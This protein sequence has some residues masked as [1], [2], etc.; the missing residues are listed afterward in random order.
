MEIE[1]TNCWTPPFAMFMT[2][3]TDLG[4]QTSSLPSHTEKKAKKEA[5]FLFEG[6]TY[7]HKSDRTFNLAMILQYWVLCIE[8]KPK[9]YGTWQVT[10]MLFLLLQLLAAP[11][12]QSSSSLCLLHIQSCIDYILEERLSDK[13]WSEILPELSKELEKLPVD[14]LSQTLYHIPMFNPLG[15]SRQLLRKVSFQVINTQFL[16]TKLEPVNFCCFKLT[17]NQGGKCHFGNSEQNVHSIS[18]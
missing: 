8:F 2:A 18:N 11:K 7:E 12:I 5:T 4:V 10:D 9:S 15:R 3:L 17:Q 14:V 16:K 1:D 13:E 6:D